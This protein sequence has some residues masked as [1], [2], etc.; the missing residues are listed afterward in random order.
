[1]THITS[2]FVLR[3][4]RVPHV[5][6]KQQPVTVLLVSMV[7]HA[8]YLEM[9]LSVPALQNMEVSVITVTFQFLVC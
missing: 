5:T 4:L 3:A 8:S 2:V 7:G 6:L 1:M 9:G